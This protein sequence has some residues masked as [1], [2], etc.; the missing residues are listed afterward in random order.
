MGLLWKCIN[1]YDQTKRQDVLISKCH[2]VQQMIPG[3]E[4]K[5]LYIVG[6]GGMLFLAQCIEELCV[7]RYLKV[8]SS[9]QTQLSNVLEW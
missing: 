4:R 1:L 8:L 9:E 2:A 3:C 6:G 5:A 7:L